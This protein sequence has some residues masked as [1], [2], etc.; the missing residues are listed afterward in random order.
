MQEQIEARDRII[1]E[2]QFFPLYHYDQRVSTL[3]KA[4]AYW[5]RRA[6]ED[7][8]R[9]KAKCKEMKLRL[10]E[11]SSCLRQQVEREL[12]EER[13]KL[14]RVVEGFNLAD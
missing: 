11:E 14:M 9:M 12:E 6:E 8:N 13:N 3:R 1:A 5:Y 2:K 4:V 7:C 10:E